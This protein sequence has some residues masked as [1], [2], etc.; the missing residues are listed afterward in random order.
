MATFAEARR[1]VSY[2]IMVI[3]SLVSLGLIFYGGYYHWTSYVPVPQ[4]SDFNT[5][6]VYTVR[7]MFPPLLVLV[8]AISKVAMMRFLGNARNPLAGQDSLIQKDK[9]FLQNTLEQFTVF[10]FTTLALMT[11]LEG[12]ELRLIP[13]YCINFVLARIFYR[14]GYPMYRTWGFFMTLLSSLFVI[15]LTTYFMVTRGFA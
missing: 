13:L 4:S 14:I 12:E 2:P 15:G 5:K 9:N 6:A 11:Y 1:N 10:V 3:G 7:C 8:F